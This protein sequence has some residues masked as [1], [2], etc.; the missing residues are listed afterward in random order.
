LLTGNNV[1]IDF[2]F[3]TGIANFV[4]DESVLAAILPVCRS[5]RLRTRRLI[6]SAKWDMTKKTILMKGFGETSSYT[7]MDPD[8]EGLTFNGSE[9]IYDIDKVTLN[10]KGVP[11][12][13]TADV[14]II[15]TEAWWCR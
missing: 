4:T 6:G 3:K 11:F 12:I 9:A 7:S 15:P 10:I 8:Q 14:K 2:N 5:R 13:Q 1:N